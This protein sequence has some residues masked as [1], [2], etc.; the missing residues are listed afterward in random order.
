[1]LVT[2]CYILSQEEIVMITEFC[3]VFFFTFTWSLHFCPC[4]TGY[5]FKHFYY[6]SRMSVWLGSLMKVVILKFVNEYLKFF[7]TRN[8]FMKIPSFFLCVTPLSLLFFWGTVP[9]YLLSSLCQV[10]V[11]LAIP[12]FTSPVTYVLL[13]STQ[14]SFLC[15]EPIYGRLYFWKWKGFCS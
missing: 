9:G 2:K 15:M 7:F 10:W 8:A 11:T 1:M 14:I 4:S 13:S 6:C 12:C 3:F 5:P